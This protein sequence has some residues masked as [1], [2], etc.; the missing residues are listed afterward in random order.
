MLRRLLLVAATA[1]ALA[2]CDDA[3]DTAEAPP[4]VQPT[5]EA[6]THFGRMILL[7]HDGPRGQIHL[8]GGE[9]IWFPAVR[10]VV[11]F[12]LLPEESKDIT[13][14]YVSDMATAQSWN[15]P[16]TWMPA[17]DALY[18]IESE[19]RGGMGMPEAVPFSDRAAADAFV[20][21]RGGRIVA[22]DEIP[23]DYILSAPDD[24][25]H[26]QH[27]TVLELL[28]EPDATCLPGAAPIVTAATEDAP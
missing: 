17:R 5:R 19:A 22:W 28:N 9:V 8:E 12:T 14:M 27:G 21:E 20:A 11:A 10:D 7:E 24:S 4:P 15:D 3:V 26:M 2:A 1:I 25:V 18:V 23:E 16:E 13:A 6:V